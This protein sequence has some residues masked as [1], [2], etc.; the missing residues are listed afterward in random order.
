M[1]HFSPD[2]VSANWDSIVVDVGDDVLK[3]V[4]MPSPLKGT[5]RLV[6]NLFR[7]RPNLGEFLR[8]LEGHSIDT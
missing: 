4:D 7:D 6:E 1:D 3:R 5:R 2:I 8:R